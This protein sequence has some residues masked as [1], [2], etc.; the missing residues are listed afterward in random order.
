MYKETYIILL[1]FQKYVVES[2]IFIKNR[3]SIKIFSQ[4]RQC[5]TFDTAHTILNLDN[6]IHKNAPAVTF[7]IRPYSHLSTF[8]KKSYG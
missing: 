8:R 4:K 1:F 2:L 3:V 7:V 5:H 6:F